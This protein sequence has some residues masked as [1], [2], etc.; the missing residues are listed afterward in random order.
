[1]TLAPLSAQALLRQ[2]GLRP[3][4]SL[5]QNFLVD[6]GWL[7]RIVQAA[8]VGAQDE[9][10][11]IGAG[12][13]SLTRHLA[14]VAARVCAVELDSRLMGVLQQTLAEFGNVRL[15]Q[16]DILDMNPGEWMRSS[17]YLVAANIPYYITSALMRHLL[18]AERKPRRLALTIQ[19]EV[20]LRICAAPGQ[21]SLLALS[22]QVFGEARMEFCI[23]AGAFY[24]AP[25]V[26][27]A[28]LTV[29]L[30]PQPLIA[31]ADLETF[32]SLAR[33]AF[34]H[35]RKMLHNAL[36]GYDGLGS[37]GAARLLQQA[38]IDGNRRAQTLSLAEWG[39]LARVFREGQER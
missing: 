13:G 17:G 16:G 7:Q 31:P 30:Y 22:V 3:K 11:E 2:H 21:L 39:R 14:L 20:A 24:P 12:L 29:R 32:F 23:P 28:L 34:S 15:V 6:E 37:A 5:G 18:A 35:K 25:G 1:M 4:K 26:D 9:V 19:K 10:L 36:A 38:E 8:G 33:A 27:S